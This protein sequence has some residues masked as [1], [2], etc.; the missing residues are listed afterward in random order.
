MTYL[1]YE[2]YSEIGGIN[3]NAAFNR[4]IDRANG[5]ITN[6]TFH[7]IEGMEEVPREV[8]ALCRDLVDYFVTNKTTD[9]AVTSKSQSAGNVSESESYDVKSAD[10]QT[11]EINMM[12]CD[13]L[14]PLV[15]DN[16]TPLMYRGACG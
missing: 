8:K 1:T 15:D 11:I 5:I 14:L 13:Y 3:D 4:N 7:R 2:E 16:G 10:V 12:V 6:A 9:R